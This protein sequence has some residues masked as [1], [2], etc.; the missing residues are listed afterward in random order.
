LPA[1]KKALQ[2]ATRSRQEPTK[3]RLLTATTAVTVVLFILLVVF[4]RVLKDAGLLSM[5]RYIVFLACGL[6]FA[7]VVFFFKRESEAEV[8]YKTKNVAVKLGGQAAMAA[9]VV[10]GNYWLVP[11][12]D[13]PLMP[14]GLFGYVVHGTDLEEPVRRTKIGIYGGPESETSDSGAFRIEKI[15]IQNQPQTAGDPITFN[16]S[17]WVVFDPYVGERGRMYLPKPST[18]PIKLRVLKQG[19]PAFLSGSSVE[20]MLGHKTFLFET[21]R[22]LNGSHQRADSQL[23]VAEWNRFLEA[24]AL[25]IGFAPDKLKT[26]VRGW[27]SKWTVTEETDYRKGLAALYN[28]DLIRAQRYFS[29]ALNNAKGDLQVT[30]AA[31]Y[32][33]YQIG[34]YAESSRLLTPLQKDPVLKKDLAIVKG[35]HNQSDLERP[36][37]PLEQRTRE[38]VRLMATGNFKAI[39]ETYTEGLASYISAKRQMP[40]PEA[41]GSTWQGLTDRL[42]PFQKIEGVQV[43]LNRDPV[44]A[45][46]VSKFLNGEVNVEIVFE[47]PPSYKICNLYLQP[48]PT[49]MWSPERAS[50]CLISPVPQASS[51]PLADSRLAPAVE[52]AGC[53]AEARLKSPSSKDVA[54][55]RFVNTGSAPVHIFWISYEGKRTF[56]QALQPGQ[57]YVQTTYVGHA[58][59]V[60]GT[61]EDCHRVVMA[62]QG[63]MEVAVQ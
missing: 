25:E 37:N 23:T 9:L 57:T 15:V 48:A 19:D 5:F 6:V 4:A 12:E 52:P 38:I 46:A 11:K 33:E 54:Q 14:Q 42:G 49:R 2:E 62:G 3:A 51:A 39:T 21:A 34:N 63:L 16:V 59:V 50:N 45:L 8:K 27:T 58:W 44:V 31:A 43:E 55:I 1:P 17:D 28:N 30:V 36:D 40:L 41:L 35:P 18:E 20:K 26:A 56:Y 29:S 61:G 7:Q 24:R 32:T 60:A 22:K 53:T 10:V 47:R 13:P